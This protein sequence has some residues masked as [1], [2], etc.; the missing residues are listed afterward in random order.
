MSKL[1]K[2]RR[3]KARAIATAIVIAIIAVPFII[4]PWVAINVLG[5][6]VPTSSIFELV[7]G[8]FV[9][10][11]LGLVILAFILA[12]LAVVAGALY[13]TG[14]YFYA[15]A[16]NKMDESDIQRVI[17]ESKSLL[18]NDTAEH[19]RRPIKNIVKRLLGRR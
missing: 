4:G 5:S 12:I 16:V 2:A 10:G 13:G 15:I 7:T 6:P 9:A 14:N 19:S 17:T 11:I 1:S 18:N 8:T 3:N